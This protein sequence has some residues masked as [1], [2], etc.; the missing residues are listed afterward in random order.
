MPSNW[1]TVIAQLKIK[2]NSPGL[3]SPYPLLSWNIATW[4]SSFII[5]LS[6][7]SS[8]NIINIR[9]GNFPSSIFFLRTA[10]YISW[11]SS[12]LH[13]QAYLRDIYFMFF[14]YLRL[15]LFFWSIFFCLK[16]NY[17]LSIVWNVAETAANHPSKMSH[18]FFLLNLSHYR[19][20]LFLII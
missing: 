16:V 18:D 19:Y 7:L 10:D 15:L 12:L 4:S 11:Q 3:T 8:S 14:S 6:I 1:R 17:C 2:G 5:L 13:S 9:S 20:Y